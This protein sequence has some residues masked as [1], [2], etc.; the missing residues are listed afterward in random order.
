MQKQWEGRAGGVYREQQTIWCLYLELD[1]LVEEENFP[2]SR[3]HWIVADWYPIRACLDSVGK[4]IPSLWA[5]FE[6]GRA[7]WR[8]ALERWERGI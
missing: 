7:V 4:S 6:V 5:L 2:G 1:E 3:L 8:L